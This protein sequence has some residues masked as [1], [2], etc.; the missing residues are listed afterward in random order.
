MLKTLK[1][2]ALAALLGA[3]A[4]IASAATFLQVVSQPGDPMGGGNS[5]TFA[6][7]S[8]FMPDATRMNA[9]AADPA[10]PVR[11]W[12]IFLAAPTGSSLGVGT[13]ANTLL[14]PTAANPGLNVFKSVGCGDS[15]GSFTILEL[16]VAADGTVTRLAMDFQQRCQHSDPVLYGGIRINSDIPYTPNPPVIGPAFLQLASVPGDLILQGGSATLTRADAYFASGVDGMAGVGVRLSSYAGGSNSSDWSLDFAPPPGGSFAV[17]TYENAQSGPFVSGRPYI[18][19]SGNGRSCGATGRFTVLEVEYG[20]DGYVSKL[21]ID[22]EQ[23]CFAPPWGLFGGLRYNSTIPYVAPPIPSAPT[24]LTMEGS[25]FDLAVHPGSSTPV[26]TFRVF[27][28][29]SNPF[30]GAHIHVTTTCG[31]LQGASSVDL[32]TDSNGE[33]TAPPFL[34]TDTGTCY[35]TGN[36]VG[37]PLP[38]SVTVEYVVYRTS[39]IQ[40]YTATPA[41]LN[42]N[43]GQPIHVGVWVLAFGV[44]LQGLP[45]TFASTVAASGATTASLS[46]AAV[47]DS[48]GQAFA[49][50][51]AGNISGTYSIVATVEGVAIPFTVVQH[52]LAVTHPTTTDRVLFDSPVYTVAAGQDFTITL[53]YTDSAATP[54]PGIQVGITA[55][56]AASQPCVSGMTLGGTTDTNGKVTL[57][58]TANSVPGSVTLSAADSANQSRAEA[59]VVIRGAGSVHQDMWWNPSEN[60]WGMS[61]VQH[62][63][64]L[65]GA[66]YIYDRNGKPIWVVMPGGA[67]DSTHTIYS[68]SVYKPMGTPFYVYDAQAMH[69]GDPAGNVSITFQD[70]NN[71]VLDYTIAGVTGRKLVTREIFAAGGAS[72]PDRSDLWW[73]GAAQNGWGITLL[74]QAS[75]LFGVWYTYD[76]NNDPFWYVM[77]GGTWTSTDTYEG[78]LYRTTSSA[79]VESPYDASKLQ[80]ISAGTFK[81]QFNGDNA[82]FTY[83]A[84]GHSGS[85]P[86]TR[87]PF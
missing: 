62:R 56:C 65:F 46:S 39:D 8:A 19:V 48:S 42:I 22:F 11:P 27:D 23:Y 78:A 80:V 83:S 71:A 17:G 44:T 24:R 32:V 53:T 49:D 61:L 75:T 54:L 47:T 60:G 77:P 45:V 81:F 50:G 34:A 59:T 86:L 5:A 31:S 1:M 51:V 41:V 55:T 20:L 4:T 57:H 82:T 64:T 13:Y 9:G 30:P 29:D 84:D 3:A 43:A 28:Q 2:V 74:Q 38:Q 15:T 79:W 76:A 37:T 87:Q 14:Q 35:V 25:V 26:P 10:T 12:Q 85:V 66:L 40:L 7:A 63:D 33:A 68:G 21:A 58:L 52:A 36:L 73:G 67:W 69:A 72:S 16:E 18:P 6:A 70:A